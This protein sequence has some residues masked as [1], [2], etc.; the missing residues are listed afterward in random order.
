MRSKNRTL[1]MQAECFEIYNNQ[2]GHTYSFRPFSIERDFDVY[3]K[4]MNQSYVSQWWSLAKSSAELKDHL[5]KELAD[6]HQNLFI[7]FVDGV[8]VSYWERYWLQQDILGR[9]VD[10]QPFDQGLHFLVG[11]KEY[12]GRKFTPSLIAAFLKFLFQDPRTLRVF[13]EPDINNRMVLRYA[14][15]TCFEM[16]G[17]VEMP[18]RSSAVMVCRREQFFAKYSVKPGELWKPSLRESAGFAQELRL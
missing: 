17:V 13:G 10:A 18:E 4:W 6:K 12:L 3:S 14:E 7:G 5:E 8:P 16:Q 2:N 1:G 9:F 15:A 11:E